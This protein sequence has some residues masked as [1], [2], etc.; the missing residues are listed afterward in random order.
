MFSHSEHWSLVL[1]RFFVSRLTSKLWACTR[2]TKLSIQFL[3]ITRVTTLSQ[4]AL[5]QQKT[6]AVYAQLMAAS[7]LPQQQF[8]NA[9][10][11]KQLISV[12]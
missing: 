12:M 6:L 11:G 7:S 4:H 9:G 10:R 5:S 3:I 1:Y 8:T 2:L